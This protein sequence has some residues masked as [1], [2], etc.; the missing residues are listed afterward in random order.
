LHDEDCL[1]HLV[2]NILSTVIGVVVGLFTVWASWKYLKPPEGAL[3]W[4]VLMVSG[5]TTGVIA[6]FVTWG[7]F[8]EEPVNQGTRQ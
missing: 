1:K 4:A 8:Q 7:H 3:D 2:G 5:L 6:F